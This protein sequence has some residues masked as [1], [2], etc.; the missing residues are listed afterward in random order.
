MGNQNLLERIFLSCVVVA[1]ILMIAIICRHI[2]I[3][4]G[5]D[6]FTANIVFGIICILGIALYSMI[7]IVLIEVVNLFSKKKVLNKEAVENKKAEKNVAKV[8]EDTKII[9]EVKLDDNE[10]LSKLF[11]KKYQEKIRIEKQKLEIAIQYTKETFASYNAKEDLI[12]LCEYIEIYSKQ[13]DFNVITP[14]EVKQLKYF[15]VYHYGWNIWNYF[16]TPNNRIPQIK[17]AEFLKLI[18]NELLKDVEI[19]V[20]KKHLK[21]D[22]KKGFIKIEE[23]ITN[24]TEYNQ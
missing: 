3:T 11:D 16:N 10:E 15:D 23:D 12:K 5:S 24:L 1:T 4:L 22:P 8:E 14:I 9:N 20:I 13:G 17:I 21:T 7:Q 6:D 18:F 19:H 2:S